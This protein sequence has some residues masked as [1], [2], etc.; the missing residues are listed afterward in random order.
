MAEQPL[1][2]KNNLPFGRNISE[3]FLNIYVYVIEFQM[4]ETHNI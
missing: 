3:L 4:I 1:K 2:V